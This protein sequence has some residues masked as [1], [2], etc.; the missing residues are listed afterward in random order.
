M[1]QY[2]YAVLCD[3]VA[4]GAFATQAGTMKKRFRGKE[5]S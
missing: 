5:N 1:D 3:E 4:L 2:L